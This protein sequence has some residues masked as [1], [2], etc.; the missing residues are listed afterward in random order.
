[1]RFGLIKEITIV[2]DPMI[3]NMLIII[4]IMM[5]LQPVFVSNNGKYLTI[6]SSCK[7]ILKL[8]QMVSRTTKVNLSIAKSG[9]NINFTWLL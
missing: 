6:R 5:R 2:R 7:L 8:V 4:K 9:L 3:F 1:M